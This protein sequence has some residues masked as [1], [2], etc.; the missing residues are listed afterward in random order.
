M[1]HDVD[2]IG[3][4]KLKKNVLRDCRGHIQ[5]RPDEAPESFR[6]ERPPIRIC[7]GLIDRSRP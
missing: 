1:R 3:T 5:L 6:G 7:R 2:S 4:G